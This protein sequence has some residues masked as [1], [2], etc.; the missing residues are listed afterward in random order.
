MTIIKSELQYLKNKVLHKY[1][2]NFILKVGRRS[3]LNQNKWL[4]CKA[5]IR[6]RL[7]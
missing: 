4:S 1:I 5:L 2:L 6:K 7:F 3:N